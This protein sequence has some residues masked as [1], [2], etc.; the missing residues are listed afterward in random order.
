MTNFTISTHHT[1]AVGAIYK[2]FEDCSRAFVDGKM[3]YGEYILACD[4]AVATMKGLRD[5]QDTSND[6][7]E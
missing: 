7:T 4:G 6:P 1:N 5:E 3:T 2:T